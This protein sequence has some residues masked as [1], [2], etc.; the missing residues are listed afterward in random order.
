MVQLAKKIF[1]T[2]QKPTWNCGKSTSKTRWRHWRKRWNALR[3]LTGVGIWFHFLS[4]PAFV[5]AVAF[6]IDG[7]KILQKM[8]EAPKWASGRTWTHRMLCVCARRPAS[9]TSGGST[10]RT[11]SSISSSSRRS[12]LLLQRHCMFRP[13]VAAETLKAC[14]LFGLHLVAAGGDNGTS[15]SCGVF[16]PELDALVRGTLCGKKMYLAPGMRA[17]WV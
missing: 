7:V 10:G 14:A 16:S 2:G 8:W 17:R 6:S 4:V 3:I 9:K 12:L 11:A 5:V 15:S 1:W 13:F